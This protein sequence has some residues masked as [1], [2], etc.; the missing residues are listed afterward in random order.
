MCT[1]KLY[2]ALPRRVCAPVSYTAPYQDDTPV[3]YT[4][5]YQ[6]DT[7]VS[8]TAPYRDDTPVSYTAPYRDDT[9][10]SYTAPYRDDTPVSY[11]AP[12][13]DECVHIVSRVWGMLSGTCY[14][15][16]P[17]RREIDLTSVWVFLEYRYLARASLANSLDAY[18]GMMLHA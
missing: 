9:P 14:L 7:P 8:Y 5:P 3:S 16:S 18:T 4:A 1:S 15:S 13:Q 12:Y 10:V 2:S 11:T 6:D 17:E